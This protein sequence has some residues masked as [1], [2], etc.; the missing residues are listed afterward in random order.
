[1]EDFA[2]YKAKERT[3]T[4]GFLTVPRTGNRASSVLGRGRYCRNPQYP[5][6]Y[7]INQL[8][9]VPRN[10]LIAEAMRRAFRDRAIYLGDPTS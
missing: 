10:H 9:P 2:A 1:M 4:Y 3:H 6:A 5:E 7:P 8:A